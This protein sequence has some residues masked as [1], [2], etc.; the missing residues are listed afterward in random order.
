MDYRP[1]GSG[2]YQPVDPAMPVYTSSVT[3]DPIASWD[4]RALTDGQYQVRVRVSDVCGNNADLLHTYEVDNTAPI[5][6]IDSLAPCSWIDGLVEIRGEVF[7]KNINAWVLEY[8]GADQRTWRTIAS[9]SGNVPAGELLAV[10]D[11][12]A[13]PRCA[14]TVRL[15]ATDKS[16]V[17]CLGIGSN[18]AAD[19]VS[20]N[21]G[22]LV[23][24]NG[25]GVLDIFDFLEFSNR[26]DAG[27]P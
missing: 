8:T 17:G 24:L 10:W 18:S 15:R 12:T 25:D 22:C 14:Y 9:G 11:T 23:D 27:C 4:T 19:M 2:T 16:R 5:A 21:I 13:L 20:V 1:L 26:F 3:T 6:R 7:D